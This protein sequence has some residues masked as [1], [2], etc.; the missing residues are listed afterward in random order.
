MLDARI[1]HFLT[2]AEELHFGRAASRLCIS[3]PA[4]SGSIKNLEE[5]LGVRLLNRSSRRVELTAAGALLADRSVVL[6]DQVNQTLSLVRG[7]TSVALLRI[8]YSPL[9]DLHWLSGV[10]AAARSV[11]LEVEWLSQ[12][13]SDLAQLVRSGR[14]DAAIVLGHVLDADLESEP[15]LREPPQVAFSR[16]H[17]LAGT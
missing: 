12:H 13:S 10:V 5:R 17:P 8:G 6:R 3:Q 7:E 15:L 9:A 16:T 1:L 4:L 2:L 11:Q 14:L